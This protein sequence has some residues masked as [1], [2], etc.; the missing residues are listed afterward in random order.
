MK[1]MAVN[2]VKKNETT[3]Y[4]SRKRHGW[5]VLV[6]KWQEDRSEE[7]TLALRA[8]WGRY[9][10]KAFRKTNRQGY[11][12]CKDSGTLEENEDSGYGKHPLVE[13]V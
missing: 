11:G 7:V 8:G 9:Q 10:L 3:E 2:A 1:Q 4:A 13:S 12:K 6:E 5:A